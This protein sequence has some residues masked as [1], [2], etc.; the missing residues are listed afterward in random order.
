VVQV[1]AGNKKYEAVMKAIQEAEAKTS[2]EIRVHVTL[3]LFEKNPMERATRLFHK[4]GMTRTQHRNGVLLYV[5][6]LRHRFAVYG[7]V[8]IH[9]T[10]GQQY[11]N[12]LANQVSQDLKTKNFSTALVL[13]VQSIGKTLSEHFPQDGKKTDRNELSDEITED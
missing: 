12:E 11:W 2:G 4:L 5:N 3:K 13:A 7:D 6:R 10:V 9:K 8:G 1:A